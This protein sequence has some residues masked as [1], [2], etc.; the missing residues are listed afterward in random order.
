MFPFY[1]RGNIL[2]LK[3]Y[4]AYDQVEARK[5]K[6]V[7]FLRDVRQDDERADEVEADSPEDYAARKRITITNLSERR[8]TDVANG[9]DMTKRELEDAID[10]A[11]QI[12]QAAYVPEASREDLAAA[13]G[14]ALA[15][16]E[17]DVG[18]EDEDDDDDD[19]QR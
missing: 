10:Q 8:T 9:N 7:G 14:D 4:Q 6:A 3:K 1:P 16:L 5:A 15:A 2:V 19:D 18:D 11:T 13:I 12:L 17:G